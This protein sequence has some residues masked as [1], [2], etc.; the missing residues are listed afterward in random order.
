M[1]S[2]LA[3]GPAVTPCPQQRTR[4]TGVVPAIDGAPAIVRPVGRCCDRGFVLIGKG[5]CSGS[6]RQAATS[7]SRSACARMR[8]RMLTEIQR[9]EVGE[10]LRAQ[11][12]LAH[13]AAGLSATR[14]RTPLGGVGGV[15]GVAPG[16]QQHART[17]APRC[18]CLAPGGQPGKRAGA[19]PMASRRCP[20]PLRDRAVALV[21]VFLFSFFFPSFRPRDKCEN[22]VC[23]HVCTAKP[24]IGAKKTGDGYACL[25]FPHRSVGTLCGRR[26]TPAL[27]KPC[28]TRCHARATSRACERAPLPCGRGRGEHNKGVACQRQELEWGVHLRGAAGRC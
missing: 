20:F 7:A 11:R 6:R 16:P 12:A 22:T 26:R 5:A 9:V 10:E 21:T 23:Q 8:M 18:P 27:A 1:L 17:P 19:A 13:L 28:A 2:P 3:R 25:G 14:V 24:L 4:N 15:L